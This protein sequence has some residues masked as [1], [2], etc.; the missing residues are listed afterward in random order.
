MGELMKPEEEKA[1]LAELR[2]LSDETKRF[3]LHHFGNC[4]A[5]E[6]IACENFINNPEVRELA[7]SSIDHVKNDLD[8]FCL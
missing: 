1:A 2:N 3:L 6:R 7:V 8:K 5:T 4:W